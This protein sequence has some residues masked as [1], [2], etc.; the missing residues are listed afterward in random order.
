M[1][2]HQ[3]TAAHAAE[4]A[5]HFSACLALG[6]SM[7][8]CLGLAA[9]AW[10]CLLGAAL[11]LAGVAAEKRRMQPVYLTFTLLYFALTRYGM[12]PAQA[13]LLL[14]AVLLFAARFVFDRLLPLLRAPAMTGLL[15]AAVLT[16]TVLQTNVYFGIGASG[17]SVTEMLR[18]YRS[19]GFHPNWRGILYG[20]IVM[21]VMIT[22][23]RKFKRFGKAFSAGLLG[24]LIVWALNL[25]LVPQGLPQIFAE[26]ADQSRPLT[27]AWRDFAASA[28][29]LRPLPALLCGCGFAIAQ[30]LGAAAL[31]EGQRRACDLAAPLS[32]VGAPG[33]I[34]TP[35]VAPVTRG[36]G[37]AALLLLALAAVTA[38]TGYGIFGRLPAAA[39]GVLLIVGA[40]QSVDWGALKAAFRPAA[41]IPF[42]LLAVILTLLCGVAP[43]CLL[44]AALAAIERLLQRRFSQEG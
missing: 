6:V 28:Q 44:A 21:V 39:C 23:P 3:L 8:V 4:T 33:L 5:F 9:P 10:G 1:K 12:R 16:V 43:G 37:I 24:L 40:W 26:L 15:F 19:L 11:S 32:A 36:R 38:F 20:T 29:P 41:A 13:A 31:P 25:W 17:A 27:A 18:A 35:P 7:C 2:Q 30:L 42:F 14:G 34:C 22:V